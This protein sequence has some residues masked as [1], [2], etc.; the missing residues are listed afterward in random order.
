LQEG[1]CSAAVA[2]YSDCFKLVKDHGSEC[3]GPLADLRGRTS[4]GLT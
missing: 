2:C 1:L 3:E 4:D